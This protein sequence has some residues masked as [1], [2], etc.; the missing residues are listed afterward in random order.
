[1]ALSTGKNEPYP[2]L[3]ATESHQ[4]AVAQAYQIKE[5]Q[6]PDRIYQ[7]RVKRITEQRLALAGCR[8]A[9]ILNKVP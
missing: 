6:K 5:G 9:A 8:L 1:M 2:R 4:I 3:W 7:N